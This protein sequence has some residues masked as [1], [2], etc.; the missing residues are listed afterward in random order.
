MFKAGP[1]QG[2]IVGR[3]FRV[4]SFNAVFFYRLTLNVRRDHPEIGNPT[5]GRADIDSFG[6]VWQRGKIV[7]WFSPIMPSLAITDPFKEIRA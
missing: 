4:R 3:T 5:D 1:L 2:E 6:N 7:G